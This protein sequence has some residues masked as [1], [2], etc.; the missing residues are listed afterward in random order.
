MVE[1]SCG[2]SVAAVPFFTVV[3]VADEDDEDSFPFFFD[4]FCEPCRRTFCHHVMV[5]G[6]GGFDY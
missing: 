5:G 6:I 2:E 3:Q 4:A 1:C